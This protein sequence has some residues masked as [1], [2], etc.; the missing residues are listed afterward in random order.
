MEI[1]DDI[2]EDVPKR[3]S[4]LV[5]KRRLTAGLKAG[6]CISRFRGNY[7]DDLEPKIGFC[8]GGFITGNINSILAIQ[9]EVLFVMKGAEEPDDYEI[10][11]NYLEIP[12]LIKLSMSGGVV[13]PKLFLGP[14]FAMNL[15]SNEVYEDGYEEEI[16]YLTDIDFGLVIGAGIDFDTGYGKI[17]IE[18][19]Y[20]L[21][22]VTIKDEEG[23]D[24]E[25]DVISFMAGYSF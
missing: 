3:S 1:P 6:L 2:S 25:N 9:P 13:A 8:G 4:D 18:A 5:S 17:V 12:V 24:I 21:G 22:L 15:N 20:T 7:W 14:A 10:K 23:Y 11:L 16:D 19:R